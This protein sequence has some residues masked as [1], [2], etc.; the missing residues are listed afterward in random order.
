MTRIMIAEDHQALVDGM[1][2]LF[3]HDDD[4]QVIATASNG[5]ELLQLLENKTCDVVVTDLSMPGMNG[6]RLTRTIKNSY[7]LIRILAFSMFEGED[8]IRDMIAAGVDGYVFKRRPLADVKKAILTIADGNTYFDSGINSDYLKENN[9]VPS[10]S[11]LSRSEREIL[12]LIAMGHTTS[13]IAALR[14]TAV[15]TVEKH[16]KNMMRK[17]NLTGKGELLRYALHKHKHYS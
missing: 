15:S 5:D 2:L 14:F 3:E 8:A 11:L 13:E 10:P 1:R 17:L 12:K 9:A 6:V 16:R 7:S 4:F